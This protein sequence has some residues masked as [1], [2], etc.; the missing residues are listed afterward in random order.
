MEFSNGDKFWCDDC[1]GT[2]IDR[3]DSTTG[4]F[5]KQAGHCTK[6]GEWVTIEWALCSNCIIEKD[7]K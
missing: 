2:L 5:F 4:N 6:T 1:D 7:S 3:N